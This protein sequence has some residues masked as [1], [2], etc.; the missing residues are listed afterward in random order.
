MPQPSIKKNYIYNTFYQLLTIVIPFITSPYI[1]RVFQ[2]DGVGIYSYTNAICTYFT[3]IAALGVTSYGQREIALHRDAPQKAS[4][5]FWEIEIM[6]VSTTVISLLLWTVLIFVSEDYSQ[7]YVILTM[8]VFATAFD[9][10]WFWGG[11]EKYKLIVVRNTVIKLIGVVVLFVFVNDKSDLALYIALIAIT[12]LLGNISMWTYLPKYIVKIDWKSLNLKR[13]YKQTLVYFVPTIAT[14]IYTVLD[15]AMI[16]WITNDDCQNGY[17]EQATKMINICK[18]LALSINT[19]V[20]SRMSFLFGKQKHNEI[21]SLLKTTMNFVL[22]LSLPIVFGLVAIAKDFVPLFF[23]PGYDEVVI[24]L[25]IMS[26]LIVIIALSNCLGALYFT[27]SG[28]RA[29]SSKGIVAGAILNMI[30]N[31]I[32]I[33]FFA[34][35]GAAVGTVI[36]ECAI[37]II[38]LYMAKDYF[39]VSVIAKVGWKPL[40]SSVIMFAVVY[41]AGD[42]ISHPFVTIL[43][44][45][46]LGAIIYVLCLFVLKDEFICKNSKKILSKFLKIR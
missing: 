10:S 29:R 43:I 20:S 9:I 39:K 41:F 33:P 22:I 21:K 23:G 31:S 2:A 5:L 44:Q 19:V 26:S 13:H 36:A 27:P 17:Y 4:K 35:R 40:V 46:I 16:G 7:Y 15:K 24:L 25:C 28:Q 6:C 14:S 11:Y 18:S 42:F 30:A 38:Y 3:L 45:L 32:L 37:T 1:S 12:G 8:T 34:A